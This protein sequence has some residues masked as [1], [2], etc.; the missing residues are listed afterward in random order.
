VADR[1]YDYSYAD[2]KLS[3]EIDG[4]S[5]EVVRA[6]LRYPLNAVPQAV[7]KL[8][9]GDSGSGNRAR[10]YQALRSAWAHRSPVRVVGEFGGREKP[11]QGWKHPNPVLFEGYL[12]SPGFDAVAGQ[13][14]GLAIA[15]EHFLSG[16][17]AAS[18]ISHV[19]HSES[20][21]DYWQSVAVPGSQ[22][23][24]EYKPGEGVSPS[25]DRVPRGALSDLWGRLIK[26][27]F[28]FLASSSDRIANYALESAGKGT[29]NKLALAALA[30]MAGDPV[31]AI[32]TS[33]DDS[34]VTTT[35]EALRATLFSKDSG[36]TLLDTLLNFCHVWRLGVIPRFRDV[37]VVP[38][39]ET[40][41]RPHLVITPDEYF[42][43]VQQSSWPRMPIRGVALMVHPTDDYKEANIRGK[44]GAKSV[45]V[46]VA[47]L[48][49]L[50]EDATGQMLVLQAPAALGEYHVNHALRAQLPTGRGDRRSINNPGGGKPTPVSPELAA[51]KKFTVA[52]NLA[53][54]LL[55]QN[56]YVDRGLNLIGRVR[57]DICPGTPVQ[58]R[59]LGD[60]GSYV[61]VFG[62]VTQVEYHFDAETPNASTNLTVS[63]LRTEA[64]Q[65][66]PVVMES[67]P[68][69]TDVF[70][71]A[72]ML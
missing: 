20:D 19:V 71:G 35:A 18:K 31:A 65:A 1:N 64:E 72:G 8:A 4:A 21:A 24:K 23:M 68:L 10:G 39:L 33:G 36:Q 66:G 58:V 38:F 12:A 53:L 57:T 26:P 51:Y 37:L 50:G 29:E 55:C 15:A 7:I 56:R 17:D 42:R 44:A 49:M 2:I 5:V 16:L 3:A 54:A 70:K 41:A 45:M 27:A 32:R 13:T 14:V 11:G 6:T 25:P 22:E 47:D 28:T 9:I 59:L 40:Y 61:D 62:C 46:G 52:D 63:F 60:V 34:L 48:S 30:R 67:H 43:V 69:F